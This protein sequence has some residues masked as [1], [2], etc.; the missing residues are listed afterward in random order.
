MGLFILTSG[1]EGQKLKTMKAIFL[2]I[3][4]LI[5]VSE[6]APNFRRLHHQR[7]DDRSKKINLERQIEGFNLERQLNTDLCGSMQL[8]CGNYNHVRQ[9]LP[10]Y[11]R[12]QMVVFRCQ[13][14]NVICDRL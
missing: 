12:C 2:T 11:D 13:N 1:G 14:I 10:C 3:L 8:T 7:M 9:H 4:M 6:A 5:V